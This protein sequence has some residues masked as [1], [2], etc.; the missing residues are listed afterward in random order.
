MYIIFFKII[1]RKLI[2]V[3]QIA[4]DE[5]DGGFNSFLFAQEHIGCK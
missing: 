2:Q 5:K 3:K 1:S 4:K